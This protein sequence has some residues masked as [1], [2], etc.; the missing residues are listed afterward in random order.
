MTSRDRGRKLWQNRQF[1]ST[2]MSKLDVHWDSNSNNE[3]CIHSFEQYTNN[4][5]EIIRPFLLK[6]TWM[7][8]P[9]DFL[10][11]NLIKSNKIGKNQYALL[12]YS[13]IHSDFCTLWV[14]TGIQQQLQFHI[15]LSFLSHQSD[16]NS[17]LMRQNQG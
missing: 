14:C 2:H 9:R 12:K 5:F 13:L 17:K 16:K 4:P 15:Q 10:Q 1:P 7:E 3:K 8:K 6:I 11:K